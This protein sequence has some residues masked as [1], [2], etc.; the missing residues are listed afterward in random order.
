MAD[1]KVLQFQGDQSPAVSDMKWHCQD[2]GKYL[3]T[4]SSDVSAQFFV[5]IRQDVLNKEDTIECFLW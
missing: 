2:R 1:E 4:V 5:E 3:W